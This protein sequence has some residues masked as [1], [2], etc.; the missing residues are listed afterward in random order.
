MSIIRSNLLYGCEAWRILAQCHKKRVQILQ[1][2]C[3]KIIFDA[4]RYTRISDLHNVAQMPYIAELLDS[5][6]HKMYT[7]SQT[8]ENPLVQ[9]MGH[10]NQQRATHRNI[11]L[12]VQPEDTLDT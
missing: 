6:V 11:F 2:K 5:Y 7:A 10:F 9:A 8:H 3:L 12:G 4:P 1:N